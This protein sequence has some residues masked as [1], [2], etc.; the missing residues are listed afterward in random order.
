MNILAFFVGLLTGVISGFGIGGGSLLILYLTSFAGIDQYIA[1]GII[2]LYFI[3]CAPAA[4]ISHIRN[5]LV[6]KKAVILCTLAGILT[7][8]GAAWLASVIHV[9]LLRRIFGV[10]LLYIGVQELFCKKPEKED[11]KPKKEGTAA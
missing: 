10:L 11:S 7:S 6:E 1:G 2:L 3:C 5:H 8:L 9:D 4:L